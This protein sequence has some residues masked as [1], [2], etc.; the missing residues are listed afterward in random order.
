MSKMSISESQK[1]QNVCVVGAGIAGVSAAIRLQEKGHRVTVYER[2]N[3]IGGKCYTKKIELDG[4]TFSVDLG[5]AVVA[6]SYRNLLRFARVLGE[7]TS[8]AN[9]Y[10]VVYADG[11][12]GT[13]RQQYW[14]QGQISKLA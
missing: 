14:P 4:E 9:P 10:K 13:M 5:A 6:I 1:K 8:D 3:Y 11:K 2:S 7:R 12:I